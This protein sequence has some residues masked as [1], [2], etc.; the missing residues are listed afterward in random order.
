LAVLLLPAY[1]AARAL[2]DRLPDGGLERFRMSRGLFTYALVSLGQ[3]AVTCLG[4]ALLL[5]TV[6]GRSSPELGTIV[7]AAVALSPPVLSIGFLV[8]PEVPAFLIAA[9]VVWSCWGRGQD[10]EWTL[11]A[12]AAAIGALPWLHRKFT[13]FALGLL[14]VLVWTRWRKVP[15]P[16]RTTIAAGLLFATPMIA[17]YLCSLVWWGTLLGPMAEDHVPLSWGGFSIG[18]PALLIDREGGLLA[19][20]PIYLGAGAA[21]WAT[22]RWSWSLVVPALALFVPSAANDMWWG[23]FAPAARFLLP[24]VPF[25]A[26]VIAGAVRHPLFARIFYGLCVAQ[27]G[28]SAVAWQRPRLL[29]PVGDGHN[30][31]LESIPVVGA[32]LSAALPGFRTGEAGAAAGVLWL[33]A[34][35]L[36]SI[37]L[38]VRA[39]PTRQASAAFDDAAPRP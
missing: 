35:A 36:L 19:W 12:G 34:L 1:V 37:P 7:A 24:L 3:A 22:R 8:F 33:L 6:R 4:L 11:L 28:I 5:D 9:F 31:L 26:C 13:L 20:A 39:R 10:R 27:A 21:W 32:T 25:L 29:W 17:F 38:A 23:G 2:A 15:W 16:R 18:A 14:F 30:R